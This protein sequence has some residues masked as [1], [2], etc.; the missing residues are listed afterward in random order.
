MGSVWRVGG[1][2]VIGIIAAF[3]GCQRHSAV[4][5]PRPNIVFIMS[6]DHAAH[7]IGAYGSRINRT[8]GIDRLASEGAVVLNCFCGNSICAPS[9]ATILTGLHSHRNGKL[10]NLDTFDGGQRTFPKLLQAAGYETAIF[11]KWHLKSEPTGFE[12]WEVYPDQGRYYNP[13]YKTPAGEVQDKGYSVELTTDKALAWLDARDDPRPFCLLLQF[14]APHRNWMPGPDHLTMYDDG[15]IPEPATLFQTLDGFNAGVLDQEMSIDRHMGLSYDLKVLGAP[16]MAG[17]GGDMARELARMT[18]PQR[19]AWT[20]AYGPKNEAF[21]RANLR[22][23]DLVRWKYQRYI[24]DYLRCV[25]AVDDSVGRTLDAL[26]ALGLDENTI[27]VY[28]SDQGFYLGDNGWYDKRWMYEESLRMPLLVRWPGQV[29]AGS[30]VSA[31]VQNIDFAPTLL[32]AAQVAVPA[33]MQGMSALALLRGESPAWRDAIYYRYYESN[34]WHNVPRHYG[35]RTDRYKLI[36][37]DELDAW[38]FFDLKADPD[39]LQNLYESGTHDELIA[40]MTARLA[41]LQDEMGDR[42]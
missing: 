12:T 28:T 4:P 3:A 37:Y 14:K 32:D 5:E 7:A 8:P 9:R 25:A 40:T 35:I 23:A 20:N 2:W 16:P 26:A 13:I 11:G 18:E 42:P 22:G 30:E 10:S 31:L 24:K 15:P 29:P 6:D 38:E 27:V 19:R 33:G 39:E 17:G 41:S 34:S 1:V 21:L 36:R